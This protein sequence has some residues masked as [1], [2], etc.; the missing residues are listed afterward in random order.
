MSPRMAKDGRR[1]SISFLASW[2][3]GKLLNKC[4]VLLWL[5]AWFNGKDVAFIGLYTVVGWRILSA[6]ISN[7]IR[8]GEDSKEIYTEIALFSEVTF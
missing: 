6:P 7:C 5:V 1:D 2:N 3:S 4:G 8:R